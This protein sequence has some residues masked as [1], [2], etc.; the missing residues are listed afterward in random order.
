VQIFED[1]KVE[2]KVGEE[3]RVGGKKVEGRKGKSEGGREKKGYQNCHKNKISGAPLCWRGRDF[4]I[5]L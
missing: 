2:K 3:E 5:Y 4:L 1:K